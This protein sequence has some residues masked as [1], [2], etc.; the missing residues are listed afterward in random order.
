MKEEFWNNGSEGESSPEYK[1]NPMSDRCG[2]WTQWVGFTSTLRKF[3]R[4]QSI[5]QTVN[6]VSVGRCSHYSHNLNTVTI[7][8]PSGYNKA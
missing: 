2:S 3:A 8:L 5:N 4:D 6:H 1:F 7:Q